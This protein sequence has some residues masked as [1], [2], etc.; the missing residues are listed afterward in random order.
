[1]GGSEQRAHYQATLDRAAA[2]LRGGRALDS[3]PR[4][5]ADSLEQAT[6]G[7]LAWLLRERLELGG[8]GGVAD[9]HPP[10]VDIAL[11]PYLGAGGARMASAEPAPG[12]G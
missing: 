4:D 1:M 9:H 10:I 11:S 8:D 6:V 2:S 5:L 7:G 3:A 12:D